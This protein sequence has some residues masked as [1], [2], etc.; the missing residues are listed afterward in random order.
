[1]LDTGT[2][3]GTVIIERTSKPSSIHLI[4]AGQLERRKGLE[5]AL[6]A[7][8]KVLAESSINWKFSI[9]GNGPDK[10][11]LISLVRQLNISEHVIF[12]GTVPRSQV[13]QHLS[14]A[15]AFLFTSVRDTSGGVNL[16]A[17]ASGLPIICIAH[18]GVG[19]ITNDSC[20]LRIPPNKIQAT[21]SA[22]ADAIQNLA[23]DPDLR[24]QMGLAARQCA[25]ES[26]S[27]QEKFIRMIAIYRASN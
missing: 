13:S 8:A 16:E 7:L 5:I 6:R 4:Y 20:A 15:D 24:I 27:W 1:M 22:V 17:M 2:P 9:L 19:D 25:V 21:I 14:E 23:V 10:D 3:E 12:L 18:Q 11:R 26:F